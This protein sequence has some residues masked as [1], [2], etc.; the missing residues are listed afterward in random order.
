MPAAERRHTSTEVERC[1]QADLEAPGKA[2]RFVV[3]FLDEVGAAGRSEDAELLV[4]ELATNAVVHT[5]SSFRIGICVDH[6]LVRISVSDRS[7]MLPDVRSATVDA[8]GGRGLA[9]V[10]AIADEW[11]VHE[12]PHGKVI[13]VELIQDG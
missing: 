4:S 7:S 13:W 3:D 11:G 1:F 8:G 5:R 10:D 12:T 2:R 9:L 6:R